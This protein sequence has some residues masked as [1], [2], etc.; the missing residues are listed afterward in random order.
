M[1]IPNSQNIGRRSKYTRD[2]IGASK[3]AST[4]PMV[5]VGRTSLFYYVYRSGPVC[6]DKSRALLHQLL[7]TRLCNEW[8]WECIRPTWPSPVLDRNIRVIFSYLITLSIVVAITSRKRN[9]LI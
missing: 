8:L 4:A 3:A 9:I 6:P 2:F 5:L 7:H 1:N